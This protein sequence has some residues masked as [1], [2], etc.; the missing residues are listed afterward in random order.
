MKFKSNIKIKIKLFSVLK[1]NLSSF[2]GG[3]GQQPHGVISP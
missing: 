3:D 1:K 2:A